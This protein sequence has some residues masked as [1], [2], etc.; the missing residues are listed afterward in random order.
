MGKRGQKINFYSGTVYDRIVL[1]GYRRKRKRGRVLCRTAKKHTMRWLRA[2]SAVVLSCLLLCSLLCLLMSCMCWSA[3]WW[4]QHRPDGLCTRKRR[5][6]PGGAAAIPL[7]L[8]SRTPTRCSKTCG[9]CPAPC[10]AQ[11]LASFP[12]HC[13][14]FSSRTSRPGRIPL[15]PA[16]RACGGQ[17]GEQLEAAL[18]PPCR[19]ITLRRNARGYDAWLAELTKP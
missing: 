1:S 13:G 14:I 17:Y 10:P 16:H 18:S 9:S 12:S 15:I 11:G 19:A 5:Y 8:R 7:P 4:N 6:P 2:H 3:R